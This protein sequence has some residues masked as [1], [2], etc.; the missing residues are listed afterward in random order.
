MATRKDYANNIVTARKFVT[1]GSDNLEAKMKLNS[2]KYNLGT[3]DL[4]KQTDDIAKI[5]SD[6][7]V[8]PEEKVYLKSR[9]NSLYVSFERLRKDIESV[10]SDAYTLDELAH[11]SA[12]VTEI[13]YEI[14]NITMDM[15]SSTTVDSS[16][17]SKI[18]EFI[19]KYNEL[20]QIFSANILELL[21]YDLTIR[22]SS[23][24]YFKN[25]YVIV[26]PVLKK[27]GIVQDN[28][29]HTFNWISSDSSVDLNDYT[30]DN[31][32]IKFPASIIDG[33]MDIS[34]QVDIDITLS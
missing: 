6:K 24:S 16:I 10:F 9:W 29:G 34:C 21:R 12:L 17:D 15:E 22:S 2:L 25:S 11:L 23:S 18:N 3:I 4:K 5:F 27:D 13:G 31:K 32:S 26:E 14:A 7:V 28:A 8:T 30:Q 20:S 1:L 33:S 19:L